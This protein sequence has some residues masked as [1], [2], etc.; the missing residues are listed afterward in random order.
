MFY[1]GFGQFC[2]ASTSTQGMSP[3]HS[4]CIDRVQQ[5]QHAQG[6]GGPTAPPRKQQPPLLV[7]EVL[8]ETP[9]Y[10]LGDT[11]ER[12]LWRVPGD[13]DGDGL[14]ELALVDAEG[15]LSLLAPR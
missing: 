12:G 7:H 4:A 13:F 11:L 14:D 5:Q 3:P 6:P 1:G 2:A 8:S 15:R 9:C 10:Q